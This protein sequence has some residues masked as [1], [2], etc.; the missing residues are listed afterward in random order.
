VTDLHT[1][2]QQLTKPELVEEVVR[3]R[4]MTTPRPIETAPKDGQRILI[5]CGGHTLMAWS[6]GGGW[7]VLEEKNVLAITPFQ[8]PT[9]WLPLPKFDLKEE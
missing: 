6:E 5:K 7:S 8:K 2:A 9:L 4:E 1:R 3:L